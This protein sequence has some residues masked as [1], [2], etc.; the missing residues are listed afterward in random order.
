M[1]LSEQIADNLQIVAENERKVYDAGYEQGK[2]EG[3][4]FIGVK[5]SDF[6]G[7][8]NTPKIADA[9][10]LQPLI[11]GVSLEH[12]LRANV[13]CSLFSNMNGNANGGFNVSL[14][15]IFMP[16]GVTGLAYT[17]QNCSSLK[18]IHGNFE[19]VASISMGFDGCKALP[20]LPYMP[21][22]NRF[23]ANDL[24]NCTGLTSLT[25]YKVFLGWHTEALKGCINIETINLADG[26][27]TAVYVHHCT[28]LS[29]AS[30]HDMIEKLA[31]MTGQDPLIFKVGETNILKID[32]EHIAMLQQKNIDYS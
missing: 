17:F 27:S 18:T 14:E 20:E 6:T 30:L 13:A 32:D 11:D 26:W 5:Y 29:Q 24:R 3:G 12:V 9:R 10:A 7:H 25:F 21:N 23:G 8:Y 31:D 15:E 19:N 1:S 4:G 16:D 28:K 22:L 2:A